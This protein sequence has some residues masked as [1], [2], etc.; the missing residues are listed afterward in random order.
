[1]V[2]R[3]PATDDNLFDEGHGRAGGGAYI[4]LPGADRDFPE[5]KHGEPLLGQCGG[6]AGF[7]VGPFGR[8]LRQEEIADGVAAGL[9]QCNAEF[10]GDPGY[11][12][13]CGMAVMMPAPSPVFCSKP[14]PPR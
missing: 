10:I 8:I 9:R 14:Q 12:N 6:Q 5:T 2:A 11:M 4:G 7:E 3:R 1:M 13:L